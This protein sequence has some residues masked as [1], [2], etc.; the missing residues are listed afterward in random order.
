MV[1]PICFLASSQSTHPS[2]LFSQHTPRLFV[3]RGCL[4]PLTR[5]RDL[6]KAYGKPLA[7]TIP[8]TLTALIFKPGAFTSPKTAELGR[9]ALQ[10]YQRIRA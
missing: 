3:F 5:T 2:P 4:P 7:S 6:C 1:L 10:E 8:G 9:Y